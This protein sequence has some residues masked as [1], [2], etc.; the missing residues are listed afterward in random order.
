MNKRDWR[1][2]RAILVNILGSD[3]VYYQPPSKEKI[4]YPA[5]IFERD[6]IG[7]IDA[8]NRMYLQ[9]NRYTITYVDALQTDRVPY[10]LLALPSCSHDRHFTSDNLHH[11]VFTI[12]F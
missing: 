6:S 2:L 9:N 1:D 11:D 8:D 12:Y 10:A 5:I 3:N 4:H 7:K